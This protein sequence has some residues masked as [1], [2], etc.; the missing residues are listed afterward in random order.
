MGWSIAWQASPMAVLET[1]CVALLVAVVG[2]WLPMRNAARL[3]VVE[4][5]QYE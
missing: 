5:L 4:A 3:S 1:V 2:A